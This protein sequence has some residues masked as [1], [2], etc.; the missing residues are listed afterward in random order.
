M[1]YE[2]AQGETRPVLN[3]LGDPIASSTQ[4]GLP[5]GPGLAAT[6]HDLDGT[7]VCTGN[8]PGVLPFIVYGQGGA[9]THEVTVT[10]DT[11]PFDWSLGDP[12]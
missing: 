6:M 2:I 7:L 8:F 9:V 1:G 12:I 3:Q 11:V 4:P 10:G 5:Y